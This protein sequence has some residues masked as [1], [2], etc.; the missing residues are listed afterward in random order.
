[1]D[2]MDYLKQNKKRRRKKYIFGNFLRPQKSSL[3]PIETSFIAT[4]VGLSYHPLTNFFKRL[5]ISLFWLCAVVALPF[6]GEKSFLIVIFLDI[7][8]TCQV[9]FNTKVVALK[10]RFMKAAVARP[11]TMV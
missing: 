3:W 5:W 4:I 11:T 8:E 7:S 2:W 10:K 6:A 9:F 1:M